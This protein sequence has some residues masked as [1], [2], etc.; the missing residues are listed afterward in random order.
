L[1]QVSLAISEV[2]P[3]GQVDGSAHSRQFRVL[4]IQM[5]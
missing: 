1:V 5:L 4:R 3:E 2:G